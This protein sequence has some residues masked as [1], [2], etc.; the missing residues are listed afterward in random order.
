MLLD[1][2]AYP[3]FLFENDIFYLLEHNK[4]PDMYQEPSH[5]VVETIRSHTQLKKTLLCVDVAIN[6]NSHTRILAIVVNL[7]TLVV[8]EIDSI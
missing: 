7:C 4:L 5:H 2:I 3:I 6:R 8:S 1:T